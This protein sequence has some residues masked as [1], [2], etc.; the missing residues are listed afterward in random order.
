MT[1]STWHKSAVHCPGNGT[2]YMIVWGVV[3]DE[4]YIAIPNFSRASVMAHLPVE[5]T[6]IM[7]KLKISEPDAL[8]ILDF[9]REEG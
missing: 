8:A 7:E 2:R 6:Y 1:G 5:H 3:D 9:M 4:P